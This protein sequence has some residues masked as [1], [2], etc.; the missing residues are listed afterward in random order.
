MTKQLRPQLILEIDNHVSWD[1]ANVVN[2]VRAFGLQKHAAYASSVF[3]KRLLEAR[4][5]H[6]RL[7]SSEVKV[8]ALHQDWTSTISR[9]QLDVDELSS[10]VQKDKKETSLACVALSAS[11]KPEETPGRVKPWT[12][13]SRS[14]NS[15]RGS[16]GRASSRPKA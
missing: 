6:G 15:G 9:T 2:V 1:P 11:T 7:R 8:N 14:E 5:D 3:L 10:D 12:T 4:P 16:F 13:V